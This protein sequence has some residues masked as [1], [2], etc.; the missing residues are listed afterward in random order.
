MHRQK[1]IRFVES[2]IVLPAVTIT[3]S[4]GAI[5]PTGPGL[6]TS[7]SQ[8]VFSQKLNNSDAATEVALSTEQA[9]DF[10]VL[11]A[12]EL[13]EKAAAIDGYFRA[14]GMPLAGTG[15][16]MV[17]E[18]E[19]NDLDWRLIPA[20]AVRESTGG[21]Y[22]CKRVEGNPFGWN[23]CK[24]GFDSV[25]HAIEVVAKNLGGNNPKTEK[26]YADKST[27]GILKAYNPPRVVPNYSAQVMRIMKAIGP[28][29]LGGMSQEAAV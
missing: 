1:L 9:D 3:S 5:P 8:I 15:M 29:S 27:E 23:S 19:K 7:T 21:K 26:Y 14:R 25:D 2:F 22:A 17:E 10:E 13:K 6:L 16:K 28:E 12:A 4:L 18:A 20:L 24:T 11:Y